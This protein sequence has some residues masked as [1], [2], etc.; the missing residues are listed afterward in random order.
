MAGITDQAYRVWM[1]K[2]GAEAVVT[3]LVSSEAFTH[4]SKRTKEMMA[5][6]ADES[7][8]G[9]QIFGHNPSSITATALYAQQQGAAFVDLNFGCPVPKVTKSGAGA[10]MM[11]NLDLM[12]QI[13]TSLKE[14][15]D[16]PISIKIRSGWDQASINAPEVTQLAQDYHIDWLFIHGRTRDQKYEGF[17]NWE[18]I[19]SL[20]KNHQI[21][22]VGNGDL[23][24]AQDAKDKISQNYCSA[25]M[26]ARAALVNPLIF[27]QW[28]KPTFT[29]PTLELIEYLLPCMEKYTHSKVQSIRFKKIIAWL[30][31]GHPQHS[32]FRKKLMQDGDNLSR[33]MKLSHQFFKPDEVPHCPKEL[34]FLKGGHG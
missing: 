24:Q 25:V 10:A 8:C 7:P 33:I 26:I 4:G 22:I 2:L 6:V 31:T 20:H 16:I 19:K 32:E 18:L 3:E 12:K 30:A 13:F 9:V 29:Q 27:K 28:H 11:K 5:L 34:S 14:H 17:S 1:R 15:L 23:M 21:P